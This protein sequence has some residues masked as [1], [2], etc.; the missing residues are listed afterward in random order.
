MTVVVDGAHAPGQFAPDECGV[1]A[2]AWAGNLHKWAGAPPTL[3]A[4]VVDPRHHATIGAVVPTWY[5]ALAFPGNSAWQGTAD[6]GPT[7]VAE[8]VVAQAHAI[9]ARADEIGRRA[10][11]GATMLAEA[12][13]GQVV[14]GRG[15]VRTVA[16][17]RPPVAAP[18]VSCLHLVA[19]PRPPGHGLGGPAGGPGRPAQPV[20]ECRRGGLACPA[21]E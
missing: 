17:G 6:P 16:L 8:Q 15:W 21:D 19:R 2:D 10:V 18:V 5:D 4:L 12:V 1:G 9:H 11:A 13:T 20:T 7:L 14:A 3:A